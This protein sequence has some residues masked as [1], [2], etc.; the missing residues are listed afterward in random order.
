MTQKTYFTDPAAQAVFEIYGARHDAELDE[1][2]H[3]PRAAFGDRRDEFLLPVGG[4]AGDFLRSLAVG[5]G[6]KN[7]LELGTSYGYSTLFLA[8]AARQT[9]G[10]L[11][12]IDTEG[13]K[14]DHAKSMLE[15]AGLDQYVEFHCGDALEVVPQLSGPFDLVLLD[16]WKNLYVSCFEVVYPK[17]SEE[18]IIAT[19]NMIY[20]EGAR[21]AARAL[22]AAAH[23]KGDLQ[24]VLLPIGSGIELSI[25]WS[26]DNVKL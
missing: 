8:D 19:D 24:T 26:A 23:S 5:R 22:R 21:E 3:L 18:G 2:S 16:I 17:L 6:A 15:K 14:Q 9:G 11:I 20:P 12:T 7:L 13:H 25:R 4:D 10:K 1:T